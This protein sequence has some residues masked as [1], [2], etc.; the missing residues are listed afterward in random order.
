IALMSHLNR[1]ASAAM[2]AAGATAATDVTGFGLAGHLL[3][4]GVGAEI[5]LSA[6]PVLE[7]AWE[8]ADQDVF[9]GGSRRNHQAASARLE[10]GWLSQTQQVMMSDAQTSGGLLVALPPERA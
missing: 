7:G 9:P 8:L 6:V 5:S 2:V 1:D 3:E 10:W 4:L